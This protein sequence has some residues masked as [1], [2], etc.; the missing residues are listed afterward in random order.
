[1]KKFKCIL[2]LAITLA[3]C[4]CSSP[5]SSSD[6]TPEQAPLDQSNCD[7]LVNQVRQMSGLSP[8]SLI[9]SLIQNKN[10]NPTTANCLDQNL[11]LQCSSQSCLVNER[12]Q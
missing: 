5:H 1:M 3:L 6:K 4:A 11:I 2:V 8:Q 7:E 10:L 12:L 9:A